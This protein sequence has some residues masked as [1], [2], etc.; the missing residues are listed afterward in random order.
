MSYNLMIFLVIFSLFSIVHVKILSNNSGDIHSCLFYSPLFIS[1]ILI[2]VPSFIELFLKLVFK[3]EI[4]WIQD[5][6]MKYYL[7]ISITLFFITLYNSL[8]CKTS[9]KFNELLSLEGLKE[10]ATSIGEIATPILKIVKEISPLL[11]S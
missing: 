11:L 1:L 7:I 6:D 5:I 9:N 3:S 10:A 4:L 8:R 2:T